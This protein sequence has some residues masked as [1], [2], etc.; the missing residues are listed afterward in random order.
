VVYGDGLENRFRLFW[1]TWV[2]IPPPPPFGR[3]LAYDVR[4]FQN[5]QVERESKIK[6]LQENKEAI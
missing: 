1:R 2:R 6:Q 4:G 5:A 3:Y